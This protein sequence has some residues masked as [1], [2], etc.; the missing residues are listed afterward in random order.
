METPT[1][2]QTNQLQRNLEQR[3]DDSNVQ[4]Q[5]EF[6]RKL[7]G[8]EE[9]QKSR[10][11]NIISA[12]RTLVDDFSA[13]FKDE[14][15]DFPKEALVG[16]FAAA[17]R[18]RLVLIFGSIIATIIASGEFWLIYRQ[19][20]IIESQT[21]IMEDQNKLMDAQGRLSK[22]QA[23]SAL[24]P[25]LRDENTQGLPE[26]Q[27]LLAAYGD[28]TSDVLM[29]IIK[30]GLPSQKASPSWN[31]WINS[32][33]VL[34]RSHRGL[35]SLSNEDQEA[36]LLSILEAMVII[37]LNVTLHLNQ[38]GLSSEGRIIINNPEINARYY[39]KAVFLIG[40]YLFNLNH[41]PAFPTKQK[42]VAL[43]RIADIYAY[44]YR[45]SYT[46]EA[47]WFKQDLNLLDVALA[48]HWCPDSALRLD[49]R[50][51][52]HPSL[53][54]I[55]DVTLK[56]LAAT[57]REFDENDTITAIVLYACAPDLM[58]RNAAKDAKL[59]ATAEAALKRVVTN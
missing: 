48:K 23:V 53:A 42:R 2:E 28:V 30:L 44:A 58:D 21:K 49:K 45:F 24:L 3:I 11:P 5:Q 51:V 31:V 16:V 55:L 50:D 38:E 15:P 57:G 34:T 1:E 47:A 4:L 54:R 12:I 25:A 26:G 59:I 35:T 6:D 41:V 39:R 43:T 36:F 29:P 17:L 40:R 33:D 27:L 7:A 8:L 56:S 20:E 46:N 14:R 10:D 13:Y 18:P 37:R 19:N 52:S 22:A 9:R 32:V